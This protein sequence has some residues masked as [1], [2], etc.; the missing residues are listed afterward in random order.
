MNPRT[1]KRKA[2]HVRIALAKDIEYMT[3]SSGF[4]AVEFVHYSLPEM[5]FE[6]IGVSCNFLGKKFRA[7][8]LISSMTG[9]YA[10]AEK[11]NKD[12]AAACEKT[13][14]GLGLGSQRAMLEDA[15][16]KK[17]FFVR[18]V[19]PNV[20]LGANIGAVQLR[21]YGAKKIES[22]VAAVEADALFV[23]LNPLQE[24]VQP[25]GDRNWKGCLKAIES[26]C[27]VISVPVIAKETGA[28]VNGVVA[29]ELVAAGVKAIDVSGAGGTSWSAIELYR[30]G[31]A[32][33]KAFWD[34]GNPTVECLKECASAVN[35]PLIASGGIRCG[36]D[37]A[38]SIRLGASLASAAL[39]FIKAQQAGGEKAVEAEIRRFTDEL[40]MAMFLTRSRGLSQLR[41]AALR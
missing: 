15:S 3:K 24:A 14:I 12:L 33:G 32:A 29:K 39:P 37:A 6:D 23:H 25:E 34:W 41:N 1:E 36:L 40:K 28:G 10:D 35:V 19:A 13:G 17:T 20:F 5:G 7:P 30:K 4:D 11:I 2:D 27:D 16:L 21:D 38:K 9:G 8:F 26:A 31:A 22:V 18:D